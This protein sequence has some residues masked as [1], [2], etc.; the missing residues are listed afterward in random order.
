MYVPADAYVSVFE[1][2]YPTIVQWNSEANENEKW[3]LTSKENRRK[4]ERTRLRKRR[5]TNA[6]FLEHVCMSKKSNEEQPE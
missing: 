3:K 6:Y 4:Q 1:C 2:V 5:K